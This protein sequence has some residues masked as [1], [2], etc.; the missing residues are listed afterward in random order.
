MMK[1]VILKK[2]SNFPIKPLMI[3]DKSGDI[4]KGVGDVN[5]VIYILRNWMKVS[6]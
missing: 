3:S 4:R 6:T 2:K 5:S 1:V